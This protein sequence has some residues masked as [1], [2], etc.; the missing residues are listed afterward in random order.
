MREQLLRA[1]IDRIHISECKF[2]Q[3]FDH[4]TLTY[5]FRLTFADLFYSEMAMSIRE[6]ELSYGRRPKSEVFEHLKES[7]FRELADTTRCRYLLC[8]ECGHVTEHRYTDTTARATERKAGPSSG[9]SGIIE[10]QGT[11]S[12]RLHDPSSETRLLPHHDV[13]ED[14]DLSPVHGEEMS[15]VRRLR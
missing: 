15:V 2:E 11:S 7:L 3:V 9:S 1:L 4:P 13:R 8:N 14:P 10:V 5:T 6:L 12:P